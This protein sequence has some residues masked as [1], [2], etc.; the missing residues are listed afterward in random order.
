MGIG[1]N[2]KNVQSNLGHSTAAFTMEV[3]CH[4][5]ESMARESAAKTQKFYESVK[6]A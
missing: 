5:S 4:V 6:P 1:D 3:Y 2:I